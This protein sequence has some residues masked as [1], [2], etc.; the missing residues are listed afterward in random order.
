ML[1]I[2]L[3]II[4]NALIFIT[5]CLAAVLLHRISMWDAVKKLQGKYASLQEEYA[6]S[7]D[8]KAKLLREREAIIPDEDISD[9][10]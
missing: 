4:L 7:L 6:A 2:I 5:T 8:E 1:N 3:A 9:D 10:E